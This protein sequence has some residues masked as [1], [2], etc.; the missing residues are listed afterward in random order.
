MPGRKWIQ[1]NL[2]LPAHR[3]SH[4]ETTQVLFK[5]IFQVI[6][7][8]KTKKILRCF[9]FVRKD[10]GLRLRFSLRASHEDEVNEIESCLYN[11]KHRQY[12]RQWYPSVYEPE[13]FKFGGPEAMEVVHAHFFTDS[14]AWWRWE[15]LR[16]QMKN[17]IASKLL[18][19]CILND[20]FEQFLDGPEEVW[21]VWCRVASLHGVSAINEGQAT[22]AVRIEHLI[23]QVTIEE[24]RI[25]CLYSSCN[26]IMAR[27]FRALHVR[28]KL[29]YAYRLV[30]P[31]MA[32]YH[33]NRY[34]FMPEDRA[35]IFK[36]MMRAWSPNF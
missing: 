20:L 2:A 36:A 35:L 15:K 22:S 7:T 34:D 5:E 6:Q 12:I 13:T 25:L 33:W 28:G 19:A 9:F 24:K 23:E 16:S 14:I 11:L 26:E 21:D 4:I 27:R 18:S 1:V 30:L 31:H 29:L 8:L 10:P 32:L 17:S 3:N